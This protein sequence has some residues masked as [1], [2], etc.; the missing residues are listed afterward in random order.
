MTLTTSPATALLLPGDLLHTPEQF[1]L[2]CSDNRDAVLS[3][4]QMAVSL[5]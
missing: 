3:W 2:V 5:R 4:P 1:E